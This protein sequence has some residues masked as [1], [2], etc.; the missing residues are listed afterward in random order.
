MGALTVNT[1]VRHVYRAWSFEI[2]HYLAFA[3]G[4]LNRALVNLV[5]YSLH[6]YPEQ[7]IHQY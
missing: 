3:S 6:F 2:F 7:D 1:D 5:S 4:C